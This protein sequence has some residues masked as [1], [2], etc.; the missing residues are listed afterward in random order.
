MAKWQ[1]V[2]LRNVIWRD[3]TEPIMRKHYLSTIYLAVAFL[4]GK[5]QIGKIWENV[6]PIIV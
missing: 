6:S 5:L 3:V 2:I 1:V 4:F